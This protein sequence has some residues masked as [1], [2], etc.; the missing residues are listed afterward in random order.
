MNCPKCRFEN[1]FD[2]KFC[3]ECGTP[4]FSTNDIPVSQT[5]TMQSPIKEL[6]TGSTFAGRYQIIEELG[7]GGMGRVYKVF[8]TDIKEKVALK[9]LK[10][11]IASDSE[12]IERFSN[13]LKFARKI[14]Q[15][16]VC[17]MYD[18]G[19]AEG[20]HF[21]TMEYVHGEDLKSMIQMTGSLNV[22]AVLSIGKQVCDGLA[23]AHSLGVVHRDLKPQ[24]IMIDKGGNAKIMDFGIARSLREKGITGASVMIGTPEY[25][26]P[27]QAEARDVDARSDIYSLG[28]ILYEMATGQVPFE[29]E[30]ALSV[31]MKHKGEIPKNPKQLNPNIP[32]DLSGVILKCLEKDKSR[33]Y[34][35]AAEVRLELDKIEKGIP[36]TER[37]VPERRTLTSREITVKFT[38]KKLFVPSIVFLA[39]VIAGVI[40]WRILPSKKAGPS[41]SGKPTLAVLYFK[42]NTGD[43]AMDVWR[44]GLSDLLI[45]SIAQSKYINVLSADQVYSVLRRMNLL[46]ASGY[47]SEDLKRIT[48]QTGATHIL[49]GYLTKAGGNFRINVTLQKA[50]S[51]EILASENADASDEGKIFPMMDDLARR[52]K[53][54][55]NLSTQQ[56]S[57]DLAR[58]VAM[59]MTSSPEAFKLYVESRKF[60]YQIEYRK[61]IPLLEKA[62]QLDPE[63]AMAYRAL[64]AAYFNIGL[65]NEGQ[66]Y[67][68]KALQFSSRL[69]ERD[70]YYIEGDFHSPPRPER[71]WPMAIEAFSKLLSLY[72]DDTSANYALGLVY[73]NLE[74]WDQALKYWDICIKNKFPFLALYASMANIYRIKGLTEKAREILEFYRDNISDSALIH[75]YLFSHYTVTADPDS[76]ARELDRAI[77]LDPTYRYIP[78]GKGS[79]AYYKDDSSEALVEF[80]KL[81]E[82]KNP[83]VALRG[84]AD[85]G[86][87][88]WT[89][90]KIK[91]LENTYRKGLELAKTAGMKESEAEFHNCLA[92]FYSRTGQTDKAL[93][94]CQSAW[95]GAVEASADY[96]ERQA[97]FEKGLVYA[98]S[99]SL[100]EAQKAAAELRL[101]A[102]EGLAKKEST[103]L[104]LGLM[105][106]IEFKK[107]NYVEAVGYFEKLVDTL[108]KNPYQQSA[109]FLNMLA[110]AY[111][112]AGNLEKAKGQYE[113][114]TRLTAGRREDGEAYAKSYYK[115]GII[116][117]QESERAKAVESY[118]KYL[119]LWKDA[120]PGR[121]EVEDARKRLEGLKSK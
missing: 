46:E 3:K 28:I 31:A 53:P 44:S 118:R 60:H 71:E 48:D 99:G 18:L 103:R 32:D 108:T 66:K 56:L 38:L 1:T 59:I 98:E 89:R 91:D 76:A 57:D 64:S 45:S 105:G 97:V 29:G 100:A 93:S 42:N 85:L 106:A 41:I 120:D 75:L 101:W 77:S 107:K 14:S 114:I 16:N 49:Q 70:R 2:S 9:L 116:Y 88:G 63:F 67:G 35:T 119:D 36:T 33:R 68:A 111:L 25:M 82:D 15:R 117:E 50:G 104:Y 112:K 10:P 62:V 24:N 61:A 109:F 37:V 22:G 79:L 54:N 83:E 90:G 13:E 4:L 55:F 73:D 95:D 110:E 11:E 39:I 113:K 17:R 19:K 102:D 5:E 34:Q 92:R 81:A 23:E 69:S 121:P 86:V 40:L 52:I 80:Q 8:D 72:P 78:L 94:E 51:G 74:E 30:T 43:Q 58:E 12:T 7:K 115:L 21:I 20:T 27:E 96:L 84:L 65:T 47:A 6:T 87:L 26:S